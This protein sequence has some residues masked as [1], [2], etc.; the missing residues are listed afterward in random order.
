M[1]TR[2]AFVTA[3]AAALAAD[4]RLWAAEEGLPAYYGEHL[5]DVARKVARLKAACC[6]GF[7]FLTDLHIPSNRC[8]SGRLLARL[9]A[10]TGMKKVLCGGDHIEA[11]GGKD[12]IDRTIADY[13]EK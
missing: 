1:V 10:E 6:D 4:W 7:W 11:F 9:T 8:V 12:S 3:G 5:A 13:Q 2:R